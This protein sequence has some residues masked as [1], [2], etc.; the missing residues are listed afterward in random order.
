MT[1]FVW[2]KLESIQNI[3]KLEGNNEQNYV[4]A[5]LDKRHGEYFIT[6]SR[7]DR[8]TI[9]EVGFREVKGK[10]QWW[11][12][13]NFISPGGQP[14]SRGREGCP[15][16]QTQCILGCTQR[17]APLWTSRSHPDPSAACATLPWHHSCSRRQGEQRVGFLLRTVWYQMQQRD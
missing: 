13:V 15:A 7:I 9:K 16:D 17:L 5:T 14:A 11:W 3:Q 12:W 1:W 6:T 8:R 2:N 4:K 10:Q